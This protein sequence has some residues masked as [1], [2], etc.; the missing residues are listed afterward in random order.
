MPNRR[1]PAV[2]PGLPTATPEMATDIERAREFVR[3]AR[4]HGHDVMLDAGLCLRLRLGPPII[5][6]EP[7]PHGPHNMFV[8]GFDETPYGDLLNHRD[9]EAIFA[10][11]IE[12][13]GPRRD[14]PGM[15]AALWVQINREHGN[16]FFLMP[17]GVEFA[18]RNPGGTMDILDDDLRERMLSWQR[19]TLD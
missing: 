6:D 5:A 16:D 10:A 3:K 18:T 15:T 14:E 4:E 9:R 7:N 11:A 2:A 12:D 19:A 1:V 8:L 17:D 13:E